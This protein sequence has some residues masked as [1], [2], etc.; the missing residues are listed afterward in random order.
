MTTD[1]KAE[2]RALLRSRRD[3]LPATYRRAAAEAIAALS[4]PL[5][6]V[7]PCA[8]SSYSALG[9]EIDPS[10][11]EARLRAAGHSICLPVMVGRTRPLMFRAW[12]CG[13]PTEARTW[14]IREPLATAPEMSPAIL[15]VPMLGFDRRGW[16][17]GYGGG[18]YDRTLRALR[19]GGAVTAIGLAYDEQEVDAVPHLDYDEPLD[20]IVTPS[21]PIRC[22]G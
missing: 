15:L 6:D 21:G 5:A 19:A 14:G 7:P 17:L 2:L 4:L 20:W 9:S 11:L 8:I 10:V 22:T 3:G 13:D 1:P 12:A 16:R 18:F